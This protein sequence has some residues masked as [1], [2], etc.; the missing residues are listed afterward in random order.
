[1]QPAVILFLGVRGAGASTA[2]CNAIEEELRGGLFREC[3]ELR[4][5]WDVP[6]DEVSAHLMAVRPTV[7]HFS[8]DVSAF[9]AVALAEIVRTAGEL[10]RLVVFNASSSES[11]AAAMRD[12]VGCAIGIRGELVGGTEMARGLYRALAYGKPLGNAFD[13][14]LVALLAAGLAQE[15]PRCL[16]R[17][18]VNV[19]RL[20][21]CETDE[22]ALPPEL[23]LAYPSAIRAV[24]AALSEQLKGKVRVFR[25]ERATSLGERR[26]E[27]VP[28]AQ[29][30][31]RATVLLTS[32]RASAAWYLGD[33]VLTALALHRA[34]PA[35]HRLVVVRLEPGLTVPAPLGVPEMIDAAQAG[36]LAGVAS[37]LFALITELRRRPASPRAAT[38]P[39]L[40]A[41]H[42]QLHERLA[43]L[44]S[45]MF[46]Q[47]VAT[48]RVDLAELG[49]RMTPVADRAISVAQLAALDPALERRISMALDQ[50][51]A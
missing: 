29:Y 36:G 43:R 17:P 6:I 3:F 8:G 41:R 46:E 16:V 20:K 26:E 28:A 44:N 42:F 39:K 7:V 22:H 12:V 1:M 40:E 51:A 45:A 14:A 30:A 19:E 23:F 50:R 27:L 10:T 32:S 38:R 13:Q 37:E 34:A 5:K 11:H 21:L 4:S 15:G 25:G 35:A 31:A 49:P 2:E 24:A 47:I 33:E 18:D 9:G 48:A